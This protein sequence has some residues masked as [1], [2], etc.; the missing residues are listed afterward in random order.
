[1]RN[2]KRASRRTGIVLREEV[3]ACYDPSASHGMPFGS[4]DDFYLL[5]LW[6]ALASA[7]STTFAAWPFDRPLDVPGYMAKDFFAVEVR[8]RFEL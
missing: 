7:L 6:V 8:I 3:L 1:M 5:F 4:G 2:G